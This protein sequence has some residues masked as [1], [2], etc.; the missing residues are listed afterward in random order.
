MS[1]GICHL[2]KTDTETLFDLFCQCRISH[3]FILKIENALNMILRENFNSTQSI[4]LNMKHIILGFLQAQ[5]TQT[6]IN[7]VL[8]LLKW[9]LWKRNLVKF[10]NRIICE[11]RRYEQF[12][13]KLI[14]CS[15]FLDHTIVAQKH[16]IL[17]ENLKSF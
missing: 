10:V 6:L 14:S 17:I 1:N 12:R 9:E 13:N 16:K 15:Q 2:C 7:F 11:N 5:N 4:K 3:S 8:Y